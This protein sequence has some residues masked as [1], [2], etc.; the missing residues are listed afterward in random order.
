MR[1]KTAIYV[2]FLTM[3]AVLGTAGC[4]GFIFVLIH[5]RF[6]LPLVGRVYTIN[7]QFSAA[8]GVVRGIG[9]PVDVVGVP[10]G[11][12]TGVKL[13]DGAALVTMQL[14]SDQVA[15]VYADA[16]AALAP[17]TPLGDMRIDLNPGTPPARALPAGSTI[18]LAQTSAPV[19]LSEL[20]SRLDADTR[21]Y[22]SALL[23]SVAQGTDRRG[24]DMRRMLLAL[25]PTTQQVS[26]IT[27]SLAQRRAALAQFVHNLAAVT[28][29]ASQDGQLASVVSAG[30]QT[31]HAL[32]QQDQ[33]LRQ[34][35]AKL[36][37]TL[38]LTQSTLAN[39]TPFAD[40]LGPTL[41]SLLPAVR[42]LP[43]TLGVLGPFAG[44]GARVLQREVRPL[45]GAAQPLVR[46]A[47]PAVADLDAATPSLTGAGQTLNYLFNELAYN[48][49]NEVNGS[50]DEGFLFWLDWFAHNLDSAT[51]TGDANGAIFRGM[52]L[53]NC[54]AL[55]GVASLKAT[56]ALANLC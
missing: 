13:E 35:I 26:E 3:F 22:L 18:G 15:H 9:Q 20:L 11:Q 21:D 32:A 14:Q 47:A 10:V 34:A 30:D 6:T 5:Q 1:S 45:V 52:P 12:V 4:A 37:A 33:P 23:A 56:L 31:L 49:N 8:N 46:E 51:S 44:T 17:V 24:P 19:R 25:G 41:T 53:A 39:L 54:G 28:R 48:P 27:R 55:A 42:R 2:R 29:A 16:T 43:A 7:A 40:K 38:A 36:P 50:R